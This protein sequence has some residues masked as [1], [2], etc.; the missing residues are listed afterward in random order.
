M[1]RNEGEVG[2][3]LYVVSSETTGRLLGLATDSP[4]TVAVVE[5]LLSFGRGLDLA[6]R[7]V[8]P[9]EAG[10]APNHLARYSAGSPCTSGR[11]GASVG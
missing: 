8:L 10:R 9:E 2:D 11:V 6:E 1:Y 7:A 3:A 4:D 5:D